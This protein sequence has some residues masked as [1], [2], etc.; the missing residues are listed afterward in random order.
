[1]GDG[2][3]GTKNKGDFE[4]DKHIPTTFTLEAFPVRRKIKST[5]Q[6]TCTA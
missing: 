3:G 1:V 4:I 2:G 6:L 5:P